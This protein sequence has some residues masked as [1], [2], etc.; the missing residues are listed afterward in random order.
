MRPKNAIKK[1]WDY[2][3]GEAKKPKIII[4]SLFAIS[5][6]G[7][8][9]WADWL[10]RRDRSV[11]TEAVVQ[12]DKRDTEKGRLEIASW[13][14]SIFDTLTRQLSALTGKAYMKPD[15]TDKAPVAKVIPASDATAQQYPPFQ[16]FIVVPTFDQPLTA[17]PT[18]VV[19]SLEL[20]DPARQAAGSVIRTILSGTLKQNPELKVDI[21]TTLS[22]LLRAY[23]QMP[24]PTVG[25]SALLLYAD[26]VKRSNL[27]GSKRFDGLF[28]GMTTYRVESDKQVNFADFEFVRCRFTQ[29]AFP[30]GG[31]FNQTLLEACNFY[32]AHFNH[33]S[34]LNSG[35]YRLTDADVK[36]QPITASDVTDFRKSVF[37]ACDFTKSHWRNTRFAG[38]SFATHSNFIGAEFD[39]CDFSEATISESIFGMQDDETTAVS[40]KLTT[41]AS[42]PAG[43][44]A[45]T[46]K[47][48]PATAPK[49][50]DLRRV[51]FSGAK[52]NSVVFNH[53]KAV[54]TDFSPSS[55]ENTKFKTCDL[56]GCRLDAYPEQKSLDDFKGCKLDW[57]LIPEWMATK[58]HDTNIKA[59]VSSESVRI[60]VGDGKGAI[61]K[62]LTVD[63]LDGGQGT[64]K[65][66]DG[67]PE[68][69]K[70]A[71]EKLRDSAIKAGL[72]FNAVEDF[73]LGKPFPL[74]L[75]AGKFLASKSK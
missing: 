71:A 64:F 17:G 37:E 12:K 73:Q 65:L 57:S 46:T 53:L 56:F 8:K 67:K 21:E 39:R 62:V 45:D 34:F 68:N 50:P 29:A 19:N 27:P 38:A 61:I 11:A 33:V 23:A 10:E 54:A 20:N 9:Y 31:S 72:P 16:T 1:T 66:E 52:F 59:F 15:P 13:N 26:L 43:V 3:C 44:Q 25:V 5:G 4:L 70:A 24:D 58:L 55:A 32:G 36:P 40:A 35:D 41:A 18:G 75:E 63:P 69:I 30:A 60:F 74:T 48:L 49:V 42:L 14:V 2:V 28:L 7:Y 6:W 22:D 47:I 51:S